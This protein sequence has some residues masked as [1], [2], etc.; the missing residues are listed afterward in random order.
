MF[1]DQVSIELKAGDGGNGCVSFRRERFVPRGGPDGGDGGDG[2]DITILAEAG[3]D[4]LVASMAV[5][6]TAVERMA[7]A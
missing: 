6:R 2:G 3:V 4:S 1:V 5:V 7:R